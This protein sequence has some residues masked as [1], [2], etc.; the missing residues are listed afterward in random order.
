MK[1]TTVFLVAILLCGFAGA[2]SAN[3]IASSTMMF[4][5]ELQYDFLAG[6]YV[7]TIDAIPGTYYAPGGPGTTWSEENMRWETPDGEEA[8][9]GWDLF[10]REGAWAYYDDALQGVI[11]SDHDAYNSGGGWGAHYDPDV[12][13]YYNYQLTF[14]EDNWYL[15]YK[16]AALGTPMSGAMDWANMYA[17]EDDVGSYRGVVPD[18]PDAND[19]DAADNGGGA[20]AWDMDW[21]WGSEVIPLQYPGFSVEIEEYLGRTELEWTVTLTPVPEPGTVALL[22]IGLLGLGLGAYRKRS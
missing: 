4:Q 9:G 12:R 21:T 2:A 5:G 22:G 18:D 14:T 20:G 15:E 19:G 10:A 6:T 8:I 7:G 17:S 1:R 13:D 11:G 3:T 16:G